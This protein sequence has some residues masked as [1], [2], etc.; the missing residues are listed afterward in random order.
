[1]KEADDKIKEVGDKTTEFGKGL[2]TIVTVPIVVIG[3]ASL[4]AFNEED[5]GMDI[6]TQKTGAS[7]RALKE[8]QDSI[9]NLATSILTDF[10]TAGAAIGEV[11]TRLG[12]TGQKLEELPSKFINFAQ[13]NN[14]DASTAIDNTQKVISA[15]ELKA[16]DTG[17]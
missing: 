17:A 5:K 14:I 10:E 15:F 2:S 12:L 6:I 16:E 8:M 1:M 7:N 3:V 9:I 11:K 4:S 13:L